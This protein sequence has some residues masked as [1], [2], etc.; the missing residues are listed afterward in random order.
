MS[1]ILDKICK[2]RDVISGNNY[3]KIVFYKDKFIKLALQ[4]QTQLV[5][6]LSDHDYKL[7]FTAQ[8]LWEFVDDI[9]KLL[10]KW[11]YALDPKRNIRKLMKKRKRNT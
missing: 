6:K 2:Y 1:N 9:N 10:R 5:K 7:D 11:D 8:D 4:L 3:E